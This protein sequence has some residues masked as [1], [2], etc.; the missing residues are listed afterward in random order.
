MEMWRRNT[1]LR[2]YLRLS[3]PFLTKQGHFF[4]RANRF[5]TL[6]KEVRYCLGRRGRPG[7]ADSRGEKSPLFVQLE[8]PR[9]GRPT[10]ST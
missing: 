8:I 7:N 10:I 4:V 2:Q 1:V 9:N 3:V 5:D 6:G